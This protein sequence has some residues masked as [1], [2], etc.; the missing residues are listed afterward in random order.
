[1]DVLT[2][3]EVCLL[4]NEL[5]MLR[6]DLADYERCCLD[7][8]ARFDFTA[9]AFFLRGIASLEAEM[10]AIDVALGDVDEDLLHGSTRT[11]S[12]E[13]IMETASSATVYSE[14]ERRLQIWCLECTRVIRQIRELD[15]IIRRV[16]K[17]NYLKQT[18]LSY[19]LNAKS[20]L[21]QESRWMLN[22]IRTG[23]KN[24]EA[25]KP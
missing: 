5:D 7:A 12:S 4:R 6:G 22:I 25:A 16:K 20:D 8:F 9:A 23:Q 19:L 3:R 13:I 21:R 18:T 24:M 11:S 14:A 10:S 1:M 17:D 2:S 15:R